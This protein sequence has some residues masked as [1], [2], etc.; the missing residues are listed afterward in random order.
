VF[1]GDGGMNKQSDKRTGIVM[2]MVQEFEKHRL[3]HLLSIKE[4]VDNGNVLEKAD[5]EF[6]EKVIEDTNRTMTLTIN[7]SDLHEFCA[8]V[9]HLYNEI[10]VKAL[11]N[12]DSA[13]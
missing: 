5:V 3:P 13:K 2:V 8:Y 7:N 1:T 4:S 6:L 12:E 10:T 9:A 11:E